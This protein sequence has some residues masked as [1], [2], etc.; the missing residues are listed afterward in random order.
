MKNI[1]E[2]DGEKYTVIE[3]TNG[4][5]LE[6]RHPKGK[7]LRVA[8]SLEG[9]S[10]NIGDIVFSL[11]STLTCKSQDELDSMDIKDTSK[12]INIVSGFLG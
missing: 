5:E 3:L 12:I 2:K 9:N 7:D 6:V 1:I 10:T 8:M 4:E 11:A